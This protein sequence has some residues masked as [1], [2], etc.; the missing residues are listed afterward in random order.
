MKQR[1]AR[2]I[3]RNAP[4][5]T[6]HAVILRH[7]HCQQQRRLEHAKVRSGQLAIILK[8]L[9]VLLKGKEATALFSCETFE[10][11]SMTRERL[12]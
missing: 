5:L 3:R 12:P 8:K 2:T 7:T 1:P 4:I 9:V 6:N 10:V 11:D